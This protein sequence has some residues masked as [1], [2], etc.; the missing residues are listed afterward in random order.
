MMEF[1]K[2]WGDK[3]LMVFLFLVCMGIAVYA[4][5]IKQPDLQSTTMDLAKQILAGLLTLLVA[6]GVSSTSKNGNGVNN[7]STNG[8]AH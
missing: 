6:R 5:Q 3:V 1:L 2:S 4:F 8:G 7:S